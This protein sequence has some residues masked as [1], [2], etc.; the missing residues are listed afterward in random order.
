[1]GSP[2]YRRIFKY[3]SERV[4]RQPNTTADSVARQNTTADASEI[5]LY[6]RPFPESHSFTVSSLNIQ[7]AKRQATLGAGYAREPKTKAR[8]ADLRQGTVTLPPHAPWNG[9]YTDWVA[10]PFDDLNWRF[11]FQT[12]RWI[13]PYLWDALDGNK[14]SKAEWKRIVRSWAEHNTP[15]ERAEDKYAWMDM[16]DGNRAIQTSIGA[17]LIDTTEQWYVD[18]LVEHRDW[19]LNDSHIVKGNHGLHQNIGL[20]VVSSV[21]NDEIGITRSIERLG[22]QILT[23]FDEEGLNL[24]GSVAY[25]EMNLNWWLQAKQRLDLEGYAFPLEAA[26]RLDKAGHIMGTLL[27]PDGTKPQ[28]GDGGRARG[29][30]G[31]HPFIDQVLQGKVQE[32][33]P[34][35]FHHYKNGFTVF[36]SGWGEQRDIKNESHTVIRHGRELA[37][38]SHYDRGSIH[39]YNA[40][41]RWISD[42]GFH[43]YQAK[44]PDRQYTLSRLAHSLVDLPNQKHNRARAVPV[45]LIEQDPMVHSVELLDKNFESAT[46]KRRVIYLPTINVWVIWDR[47]ASEV[48]DDIRQQWLM[49]VDVDVNRDRAE[50]IELTANEKKLHMQW[51]GDQPELD[52]MVGD[53]SAD[54]KRGLIGVGWKKMRPATSVHA[55]FLAK[56]VDSLVVISD[57]TEGDQTF[58]VVA[59]DPMSR[60]ELLLTDNDGSFRL[61]A[62]TDQTSF[63]PVI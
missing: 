3:V 21:L 5:G 7:A 27:L 60:F 10:D 56:E 22:D 20:F 11:Q 24:E 61:H 41:Q 25:H 38:H 31:L 63:E 4:T 26:K 48:E 57:P 16:T 39:L 29:R 37:R 9:D 46:W 18:L 58:E 32:T 53:P 17:P 40:G 34:P 49:D 35:T 45:E 23:V 14:E 8:L 28:I 44:S 30:K 1:M 12:L 62:E 50:L 33:N 19:L 51:L 54:T 15:P 36:R 43:S 52:I 47:I 13:N 6:E 59:R 2:W 42:G 55:N